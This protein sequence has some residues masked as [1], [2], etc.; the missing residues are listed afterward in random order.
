MRCDRFTVISDLPA[1]SNDYMMNLI[2]SNAKIREILPMVR[3]ST[4]AQQNTVIKKGMPPLG[5]CRHKHKC[6]V[7]VERRLN[8]ERHLFVLKIT[9]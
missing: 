1:S 3:E 6:G 4:S 9:E 5:L 2:L 7:E 8:E